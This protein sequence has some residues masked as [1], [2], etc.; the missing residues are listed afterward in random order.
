[1][2]LEICNTLERIVEILQAD[3]ETDSITKIEQVCN[4]IYLKAID[5]EE[6][7][8][9]ELET[10][11]AVQREA[12]TK[13]LLFPLQSRRFRWS[14]WRNKSGKELLDF[15]RNNVFPY[16]ASLDREDS[17]VANYFRDAQLKLD[18][19]NALKNIIVEIDSIDFGGLELDAK[20]E[21]IEFLIMQLAQPD[22]FAMYRTP[23][24]IRTLMVE[25]VSP[26]CGDTIYDPAC[27]TG[28][29]LI[30]S[31]RYILAKYSTRRQ[32]VPIYG[33]TW[34][35]EQNRSIE[36]LIVENP[37][38][39]TFQ[40]GSGD[41]IPNWEILENS[42]FGADIS[43]S[44]MRVAIANLMLNGIR[45]ADIRCS[46]S[47]EE[48]DRL[49]GENAMR[50]FDVILSNPPLGGLVDE[51]SSLGSN[52]PPKSRRVELRFLEGMMD[53]L[54]PGGRCAVIVP[55]SLLYV[56]TS[57][58]VNIRRKL[59]ENYDVLAVI[60]LPSGITRIHSDVK[61]SVLIFQRPAECASVVG[62]ANNMKKV[63]FYDV[64]AVGFDPR[65]S[66]ADGRHLTQVENDIPD[67]IAQWDLYRRS[68]FKGPTGI[69]GEILLNSETSDRRCWWVTVKTIKE[70]N[71]NLVAKLYKPRIVEDYSEVDAAQLIRETLVIEQD[72]AA[73]LEQLLRKVGNE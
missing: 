72:I 56:S 46:D 53:S 43:R 21:I 19:P 1:M 49:N 38:L 45:R 66:N 52:L 59:I 16:M 50:K 68:N 29:F 60:S 42:I 35:E 65:K 3:I 4:L 28:G 62:D 17:Q 12:H 7:K 51:K 63:W 41:K 26:D 6:E 30:D 44:I 67:L 31:I 48:M 9:R 69:E 34:L 55:D 57:F 13:S 37:N 5:E 47:V 39:Q 64:R 25:M 20:S 32:E 73:G 70:N 10:S 2:N 27:G 23:P 33:R 18:D 54:A 58:R 61:T 14:S 22:E 24:Q 36:E 40:R 8:N 15:A 71:Y 11:K